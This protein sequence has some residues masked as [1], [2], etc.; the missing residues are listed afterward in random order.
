[1]LVLA[2]FE[3]F[4]IASRVA[5]VVIYPEKWLS[6]PTAQTVYLPRFGYRHLAIAASR[7]GAIATAPES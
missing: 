2:S 4:W 5:V 3:D 6:L 7:I 1:M